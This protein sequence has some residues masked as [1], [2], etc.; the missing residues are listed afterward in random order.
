MLEFTYDNVPDL[1]GYLDRIGY[2]SSR[3]LTR[4]NLNELVRR[5]QMSVP[6]ESLDCSIYKKTVTL[7]IPHL[8]EK[9]VT[10]RRGGYC[11]E[12]NGI[13]VAML[14]TFGFDAVSV[15]CRLVGNRPALGPVMHR[16]CLIRLDGKKYF[17]DVGFGGAMAPFAVEVSEQKQTVFDET[18]WIEDGQE[19]WL[20]LM[21]LKHN[22]IGDEGIVEDTVVPVLY[23]A[24]IAFPDYDFNAINA[25]TSAPESNF[26]NRVW[27]TMRTESGYISLMNTT[28]TVVENRI[29]TVTELTENEI[30]QKLWDL[31][32]LRECEYTL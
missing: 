4:D 15:M 24:P 7:D 29:K 19:G 6:F 3:E 14:R 31:F 30:P 21:R 26:S 5:H 28:L 1:D 17:A 27:V 18:Y 22:G 9:V 20:N 23:F 11:F 25:L 12:L 8:F 16:G 13:F 2:H 10:N 32:G